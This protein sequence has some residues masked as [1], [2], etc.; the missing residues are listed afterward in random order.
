MKKSIKK[1][2]TVQNLIRRKKKAY[3]EKTLENIKTIRFAR[4]RSPS[5]NICLEAENGSTFNPYTKFEMFEKLFYNLAND[6]VQKLPVAANKFGN[7]SVED[8]YM[9]N[10]SMLN[11]KN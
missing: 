6:L 5:T 9:L 7:K 3:F 8:Y 4:Q 2:E 1:H 10:F 11:L